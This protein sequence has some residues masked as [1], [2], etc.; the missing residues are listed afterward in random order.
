[1]AH[2][3]TC[4]ATFSL[5]LLVVISAASRDDSILLQTSASAVNTD[6]QWLPAGEDLDGPT[7]KAFI[8]AS[9]H[10]ATSPAWIARQDDVQQAVDD[11]KLDDLSLRDSLPEADE[12]TPG[13]RSV[14]SMEIA[15]LAKPDQKATITKKVSARATKSSSAHP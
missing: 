7:Y 15:G 14:V 8:Q 12:A 2:P 9:S 11:E 4:S 10:S 1:M 6:F 5:A 3:S 13:L